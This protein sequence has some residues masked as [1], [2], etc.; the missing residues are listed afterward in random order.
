[1]IVTTN[2]NIFNTFN[3]MPRSRTCSFSLRS[4][5]HVPERRAVFAQIAKPRSRTSNCT[6]W[7]CAADNRD[8]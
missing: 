5:H 6:W 3:A 7:T 2:E 4:Q 1:M 8:D